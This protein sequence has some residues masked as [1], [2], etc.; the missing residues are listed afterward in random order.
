MLSYLTPSTNSSSKTAGFCIQKP[1]VFLQ[2]RYL[3]TLFSQSFPYSLLI[4]LMRKFDRSG[5][6]LMQSVCRDRIA[7]PEWHMSRRGHRKDSCRCGGSRT[8][9]IWILLA[10][11]I[12]AK[13]QQGIGINSTPVKRPASGFSHII[14]RTAG[15]A[16]WPAY[17]LSAAPFTLSV[18]KT[19][20]LGAA[21]RYPFHAPF[22]SAVRGL[23]SAP[24]EKRE[25]GAKQSAE[26]R[27]RGQPFRSMAA[28]SVGDSTTQTV[29]WSRAGL[30]QTAHVSRSVRFWQIL[31]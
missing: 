14:L 3:K 30:E 22:P 23:A 20:P 1:A 7:W 12:P 13:S 26:K 25:G 2:N 27:R 21:P 18:P 6:I 15:K 11:Q 29:D 4:F 16:S 9:R 5:N 19:P 8:L 28:T 24:N 10:A 17:M 31:H